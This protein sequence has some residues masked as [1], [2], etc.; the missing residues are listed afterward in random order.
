[1]RPPRRPCWNVWNAEHWRQVQARV[2]GNVS[3][4]SRLVGMQKGAA[5]LQDSLAVSYKAEGNLTVWP[6]SH[7][8]WYSPKW[9]ENSRPNKNMHTK[10]CN[11]F[12]HN[13]KYLKTPGRAFSR[14]VGELWYIHTMEYYSV[15]KRNELSSHEGTQGTLNTNRRTWEIQQVWFQTTAIK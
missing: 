14:W 8:P 9:V 10:V 4:P 12:S 6:S 13:C 1:M 11:N 7:T 15:I 5:P 2:R 3:S